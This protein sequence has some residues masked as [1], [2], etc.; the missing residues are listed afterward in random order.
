MHNN[1]VFIIVCRNVTEQNKLKREKEELTNQLY[2]TQRLESIGRLAGGV[3]HEFN[4]IIH[5][6]QGHIDIILL[7]N[8]IENE[9]VIKHLESANAMVGRAGTIISQLLGF[10]RKNKHIEKN[11]DIGEIL[12]HTHDMFMPLTRKTLTMTVSKPDF[13]CIVKGNPIQLQQVFLN[14]LIN[15]MDALE[16]VERK[17]KIIEI[18]LSRPNSFPKDWKPLKTDAKPEDYYEVFIRDNGIG[19][20]ESIKK[21]IFE[22]FYTT[23]E[24]GKGT[25]MG[26]ALVYGE[27]SG[28][29]G[30]IHVVSQPES[31]TI[32]YIYLPVLKTPE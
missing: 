13:P 6:I 29:N 26:L 32:F 12:M 19:M 28:C 17:D 2:H 27:I 30:F 18:K 4:N 20:E 9:D 14:L 23:K 16:H 31:G 22:P 5:A 10:A 25:G 24:V 1:P 11:V 15:A 21:R 8:K 7:F 3:A